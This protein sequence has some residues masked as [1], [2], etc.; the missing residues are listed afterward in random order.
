M[1]IR[2]TQPIRKMR[3]G[4]QA[5]L[6][7]CSDGNAY[8][9]KFR[10]NPQH[11][12]VLINEWIAASLLRYLGITT[13]AVAIVE[14]TSDFL[15]QFPEVCL[16]LHSRR[17]SVEP[18]LH[19]G[20]LFLGSPGGTV[21]YDFLPDSLL[22]DVIN[23]REFPGV[24]AFDKWVGNLDARQSIFVRS[25]VSKSAFAAEGHCRKYFAHMIDHGYTFGGP[26]WAFLDSPLQGLYPWAVAYEH[27]TSIYDFHPWLDRITQ[28]PE[29]VVTEMQRQIPTEWVLDDGPFLEH[30]LTMLVKR[31]EL[32][33]DLIVSCRHGRAN[34]FPAWPLRERTI[35]SRCICPQSLP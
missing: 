13:P 2:A 6:L 27:V 5:H 11:R 4:S 35:G 18:G 9:V 23:I 34:L 32:V 15:D 1:G 17:V 3:G 25:D 14:V 28:F 29:D 20:S 19:F 10:N 7:Q 22:R 31:R 33:E 8:V 12:R 26:D 30:I 16:H 21:V 24:L